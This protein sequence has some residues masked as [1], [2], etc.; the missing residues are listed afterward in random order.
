MGFIHRILA[1]IAVLGVVGRVS[2]LP[3]GRV[4]RMSLRAEAGGKCCGDE[5]DDQC[6]GEE[7]GLE[8]ANL[9][10]HNR[11]FLS[12]CFLPVKTGR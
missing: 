4:G 5:R 2:A 11:I 3:T 7:K 9:L 6:E 10:F 1:H 8:C 12:C